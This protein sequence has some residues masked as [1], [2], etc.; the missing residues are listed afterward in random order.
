LGVIALNK[1][2]LDSTIF[3]LL[4]YGIATV[5]AFAVVTLV[6]DSS[7]EVTDLNRWKGLGK[8][9]PFA[10]STFAFFL[11]AFAGVLLVAFASED[12][13]AYTQ[14]GR[15]AP[16]HNRGII[17]ALLAAL[18]ETGIFLAVRGAPTMG[19]FDNINYNS[20]LK[21]GYW[22]EKMGLFHN[23]YQPLN[24][25]KGY[26]RNKIIKSNFFINYLAKINNR[27]RKWLNQ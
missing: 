2:G 19:G 8:R 7:G 20:A 17:M 14:E 5:G 27:I 10:A 13:P 24:L 4:A 26:Y 6:R 25:S 23:Y 11:L 18:T 15:E 21:Y 16:N 1:S 12:D 22:Q 3:Y 9:S